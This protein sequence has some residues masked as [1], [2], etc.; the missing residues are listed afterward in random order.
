MGARRAFEKADNGLSDAFRCSDR[1]SRLRGRYRHRVGSLGHKGPIHPVKNCV[2]HRPNAGFV[3]VGA[4]KI[5][6]VIEYSG[7]QQGRVNGGQL[8]A[9]RAQGGVHVQK[10]IEPS[11]IADDTGAV[12][13]LW[14]REKGVQ[15]G[16]DPRHALGS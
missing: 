12:G 2:R 1:A 4:I 5:L 8:R 15:G 9:P 16:L 11:F 3:A 13:P 6:F 7:E 14:P 10:M